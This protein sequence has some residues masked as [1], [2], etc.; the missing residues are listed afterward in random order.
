MRH[1]TRAVVLFLALLNYGSTAGRTQP[2]LVAIFE[3]YITL[4]EEYVSAATG[5]SKSN[6]SSQQL[7]SEAT[8]FAEGPLEL[9]IGQAVEW[10]CRKDNPTLITTLL[11]LQLAT[12]NSASES[13]ATA[14]GHMFACQPESFS[15]VFRA[16]DQGAQADLYPLVSFGFENA[17]YEKPLADIDA[18]A[19]RAKLHKLKP[20]KDQ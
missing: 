18:A 4:N 7:S 16:M 15:K 14:L 2:E 20:Q 8:Q 1:R 5:K 6:K 17:L 9:A 11:K 3:R 13:P 19:L 12:T 10:V